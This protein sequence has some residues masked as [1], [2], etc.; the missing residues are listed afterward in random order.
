[1]A[2]ETGQTVLEI[3]RNPP[4][5]VPDYTA[6]D[7]LQLHLAFASSDPAADRDRLLAAGATRADVEEIQSPDGTH[8]IMLRDPWGFPLQLCRRAKPLC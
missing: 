3:Y 6:M 1:M 5:R 7:P 2:D 8:I 4:D